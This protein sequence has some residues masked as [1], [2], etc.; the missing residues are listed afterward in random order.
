MSS[1]NLGLNGLLKLD[2]VCEEILLF[3]FLGFQRIFKQVKT[4]REI[5]GL[6][7]ETHFHFQ[8]DSDPLILHFL[9]ILVF[10]K[11]H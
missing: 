6:S 9:K 3:S 10:E 2:S 1:I 8:F 7:V 11:A 4:E 5:F